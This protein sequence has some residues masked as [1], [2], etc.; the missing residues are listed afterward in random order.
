[1]I[2]SKILSFGLF[3]TSWMS[4]VSAVLPDQYVPAI[5]MFQ[6]NLRNRWPLAMACTHVGSA[7]LEAY[8]FDRIDH[9]EDAV[10]RYNP[11]LIPGTFE[12]PEPDPT[13]HAIFNELPRFDCVITY[14]N[15]KLL[16][17]IIQTLPPTIIIQGS[18]LDVIDDVYV[19]FAS[20]LYPVIRDMI[21]QWSFGPYILQVARLFSL[22]RTMLDRLPGNH[23][24]RPTLVVY[25][26]AISRFHDLM[27]T[28]TQ[29]NDLRSFR[30]TL[31]YL[32]RVINLLSEGRDPESKDHSIRPVVTQLV[33]DLSQTLLSMIATNGVPPPLEPGCAAIPGTVQIFNILPNLWTVRRLMAVESQTPV[34]EIADRHW[35]PELLFDLE[36]LLWA[37]RGQSAAW[38]GWI[39]QVGPMLDRAKR[40]V[41]IAFW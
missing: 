13:F 16:H 3:S 30:Q 1:M 18:I 21:G 2:S 5:T 27:R 31:S 24:W 9:Y 7:A 6:D 29:I 20:N 35:F 19:E 40:L 12:V 33:Q 41:A 8:F 11:N 34:L 32:T 38:H 4:S 36:N 37:I 15:L 17:Q 23:Q 26:T 28:H 39:L 22:N 25:Q 14:S 10:R